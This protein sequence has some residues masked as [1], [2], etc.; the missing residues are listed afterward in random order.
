M[1]VADVERRVRG[2]AHGHAR[3]GFV[4]PVRGRGGRDEVER[5]MVAVLHAVDAVVVVKLGELLDER[6]HRRSPGA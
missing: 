5:D 1:D 6:E 3:R 2:G 4:T